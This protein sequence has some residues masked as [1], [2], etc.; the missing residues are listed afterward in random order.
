MD[1]QTGPGRLRETIRQLERKLGML[2]DLQSACCGITFAQCHAI[3]EIGRAGTLSLSDLA[4][5]L[6]L[7]KSTMSRT[8]NNLVNDGLVFRDLDTEDR[9]YVRI[10]LTE[11]GQKIFEEIEAT[12]KLYFEKVYGA[13][14]VNKQEQVLESMVLLVKAFLTNGSCTSTRREDQ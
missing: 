14:P 13:I 2:N 8:I 5:I 3:V 7:D 1:N 9:R 6:G 10:K 12:M 11:N 4:D